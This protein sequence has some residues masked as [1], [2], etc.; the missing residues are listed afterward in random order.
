MTEEK[1]A[2]KPRQ[3]WNS[4]LRVVKGDSTAKLVEDFTAEMTLVAEGLVD[5]QARL[6]NEMDDL[7]RAQERDLQRVETNIEALNTTIRENQ[8]DTDAKLDELSKRLDGIQAQ[9]KSKE[10]HRQKSEKQDLITRV[11]IL[12]AVICGAWV[13]VTLLQLFR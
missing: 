6:R 9:L 13:L 12:A 3:L 5:D 8:R 1:T 10:Q 11:T 4:A 2:S 7:R